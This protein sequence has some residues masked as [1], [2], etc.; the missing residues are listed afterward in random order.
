MRVD[1][2]G[3]G[4]I[5][6]ILAMIIALVFLVSALI[7]KAKAH[8]QNKPGLDDWYFSLRS[9][10]NIPCCGGPSEDATKLEELQWRTKGSS[11]EVFIDGGWIDVPESAVV[12]VPNK[13]GRAL[14]W[15]SY[16][17]GK[18]VV[19]CFMPGMLT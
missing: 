14:V 13:D 5:I 7:G 18:P 10:G 17:D 11:F 12:P 15:L 6:F 16:A 3:A 2:G 8:D 19:R 9:K 4:W 1:R